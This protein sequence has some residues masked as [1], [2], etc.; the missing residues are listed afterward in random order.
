[1]QPTTF[2]PQPALHGADS[3]WPR[4]CIQAKGNRN[5]AKVMLPFH[6]VV[7]IENFRQKAYWLSE[8]TL[9]VKDCIFPLSPQ[10]FQDAQQLQCWL[11]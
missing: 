7:A 8:R 2:L 9:S 5:Q 4:W 10:I 1:V 3:P 11:D 6:T